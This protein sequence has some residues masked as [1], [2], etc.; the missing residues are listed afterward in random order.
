MDSDA[1]TAL[2]SNLDIGAL[3]NRASTGQIKAMRSLYWKVFLEYFPNLQ[4][5]TWP[6][7]LQKE[8]SGYTQ[9]K[10]KFIWDPALESKKEAADLTINNPLSL[11][12][13]SPWTQYFQDSELQKTIRQD[14]ERTM[15]EQSHFRDASVQEMMT[16]IL[17]IWCKLNPS[18]SYRQGMH[19][20]LA[21]IIHVVDSDKILPTTPVS[22]TTRIEHK[23]FDAEYVEHDAFALFDRI[24]RPAKLWFEVGQEGDL[25]QGA[26]NQSKFSSSSSK[27]RQEK[28]IP[29]VSL[30]LHIQND[31]VRALDMK[32]YEHLNSLQ[33]EPQLYG[34]RWIRLLFGREFLFEDLLVLWD[35][36]FA[37]DSNLSLV[38]WICA[39]ML[40]LLKDQC[41]GGDYILVLQKLMKY[42]TLESLGLTD[43]PSL[44]EM[45]KSLRNNYL[46]L[47]TQNRRNN[48]LSSSPTTNTNSSRKPPTPLSPNNTII[49]NNESTAPVLEALESQVSRLHQ[50]SSSFKTRDKGLTRKLDACITLLAEILSKPDDVSISECRNEIEGVMD[51]LG[52]VKSELDFGTGS[53]MSI[54]ETPVTP[55]TVAAAGA[56]ASATPQEH[57][58]QA[59]N[60]AKSAAAYLHNTTESNPYQHKRQQQQQPSQKQQHRRES[61]PPSNTLDSWISSISTAAQ[62]VDLS[63]TV[64][65]AS[66][67]FSGL[68]EDASGSSTAATT[69]TTNSSVAVTGKS[70]FINP[71]A[72]IIQARKE[73]EE[74]H[75]PVTAP[76][77]S[78]SN[79]TRKVSAG[80][81]E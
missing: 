20:L 4:L 71:F 74:M 34:L 48:S 26:R 3:R 30:C 57:G 39:A 54:L 69:T 25:R 27:N 78:S 1:W 81:L 42:P 47:Q 66:D 59:Q 50:Q 14:V 10:Q 49:H 44:I 37:E 68:F 9:L 63:K 41:L 8:R 7:I 45:A 67:L 16:N 36:I 11:D 40:L 64:K 76:N 62:E 60:L 70:T 53:S 38:E 46:S 77:P 35:G 24:M 43:I 22:D 23:V 58:T 56:T 13:Q 51:E 80:A 19:E 18:I 72:T 65:V 33:I 6:V 21:P 29:I 31:I 12:E 52:V 55:S 15:P 75:V 61:A 73:D 32:F 79:S 5:A 28:P 17:F 2:I